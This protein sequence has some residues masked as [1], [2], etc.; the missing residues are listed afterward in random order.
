MAFDLQ[1][2]AGPALIQRVSCGIRPR[3]EDTANE[4]GCQSTYCGLLSA[5]GRAALGLT[6]GRRETNWHFR[7]FLQVESR[8]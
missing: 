3:T 1:I 4:S 5:K 6:Y 8:R 7:T 2:I